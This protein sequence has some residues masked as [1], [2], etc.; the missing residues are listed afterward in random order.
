M[1][2]IALTLTEALAKLKREHGLTIPRITVRT[3]QQRGFWVKGRFR[4]GHGHTRWF[5]PGEVERLHQIV[6][7]RQAGLPLDKLQRER[8]RV[9][10]LGQITERLNS[11]EE[12][13]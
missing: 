1:R 5:L 13:L 4:P 6:T 8:N 9:K 12:V 2:S 11:S 7:D 3:W 10:L